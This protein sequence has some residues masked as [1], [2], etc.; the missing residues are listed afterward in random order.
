LALS[1]VV[2]SQVYGGAG[3][4][5]SNCSPFK[6]D[7]VELFN[8]GSAPQALSGW[9]VQYSAVLGTTWQVTALSN[10]TL[11]PGQ[12]YLVA[13]AFNA[14]GAAA[15][16]TADATGTIA[17]SATAGKVALVNK[18]TALSGACPTGTSV[19]DLVG[20]GSA[21]NCSETAPAPAPST[22]KA[23]VRNGDGCADTGNNAV[24]F[25]AAAP[26][27]RNTASLVQPCAGAQAKAGEPFPFEGWT[28][29][30]FDS[31]LLTPARD[32]A[33]AGSPAYMLRGVLLDALSARRP[34]VGSTRWRRDASASSPPDTRGGR[35]PP[36]GAWP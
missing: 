4:T 30:P 33:P 5:T 8:R 11:Q 25:V 10:V 32:F 20:Y 19:I 18:T 23:V 1:A 12:R 17:M 6:N 2:I 7:Y 9:S 34:S 16:P 21:A 24:D 27:P 28:L 14:N 22:T 35:P 31:L 29:P 36:Q 13:E 3:C 26:N 15:V